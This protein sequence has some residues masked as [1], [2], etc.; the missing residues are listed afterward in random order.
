MWNLKYGTDE[1]IY[2]IETD[3]QTWKTELRLPRESGEGVGLVD[4]NYYIQNG[5]AMESCCYITGKCVHSLAIEH[6]GGMI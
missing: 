3:L 2:R 4:S 6:D 5:W 1:P